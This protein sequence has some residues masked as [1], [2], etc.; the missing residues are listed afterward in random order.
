MKFT[1][2][3]GRVIAA[4]ATASLVL[5]AFGATSSAVAANKKTEVTFLTFTSPSLTKSFWA[6]QAKA[7]EK[8]NPGISIKLLFT[9]TLDRQGYACLLYTS[10]AADD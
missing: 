5:T 1:T 4:V 3:K 8:A 6:T 2:G 10:D 7:I 9:P